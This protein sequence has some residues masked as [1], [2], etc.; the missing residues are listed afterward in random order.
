PTSLPATAPI[1]VNA[2]EVRDGTVRVDVT[3]SQSVTTKES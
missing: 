1:A 3:A 2:V